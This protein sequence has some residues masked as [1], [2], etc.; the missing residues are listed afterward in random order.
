MNTFVN[1]F[2]N[3]RPLDE[4]RKSQ[5]DLQEEGSSIAQWG[6]NAG[7][8]NLSKGAPTFNLP[9]VP[10]VRALS[11]CPYLEKESNIVL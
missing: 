5:D 11:S 2:S 4:L 10:D 7:F 9:S 3:T 1:R 8:G 6:S